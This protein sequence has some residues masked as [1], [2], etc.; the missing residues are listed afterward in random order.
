MNC[1]HENKVNNI[2]E[3]NL[4]HDIINTP[5]RTKNLNSHHSPI[6]HGFMN[7]RNDKAK[8]ENFRIILD[9]G[10]SSSI[11]MGRLVEKLSPKDML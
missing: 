7:T 1:I 8:I 6:L 11:I 10:F 9:I 5:K 3:F 4:I 2:A